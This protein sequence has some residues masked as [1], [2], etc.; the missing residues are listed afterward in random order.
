MAKKQAVV[1][2]KGLKKKNGKPV[3][4]AGCKKKPKK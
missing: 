1:K 4:G 2:A 3:F